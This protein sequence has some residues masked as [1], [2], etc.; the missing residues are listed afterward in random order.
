MLFTKARDLFGDEELIEF[1]KLQA[2]LSFCRCAFLALGKLP[3]RCDELGV[4]RRRRRDATPNSS[5]CPY[6]RR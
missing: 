1:F 5:G 6:D 3:Q 4:N 2:Q